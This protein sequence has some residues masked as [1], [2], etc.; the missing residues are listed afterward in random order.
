[1]KNL[2]C[3]KC[4]SSEF[5]RKDG[6]YVCLYCRS[7]VAPEQEKTLRVSMDSRG[8][9]VKFDASLELSN[10]YELA[11]RYLEIGDYEK[12]LKY[13]EMILLQDP[14]NWEATFYIEYI[15]AAKCKLHEIYREGASLNNC[16]NPVMRLIKNHISSKD[17][18]IRGVNEVVTRC[19]EL[20]NLFYRSS[21]NHFNSLMADA[22][23]AFLAAHNDNLLVAR[24][25]PYAL[26][27]SIESC[28]GNY[29]ELHPIMVNSWKEGIVKHV[30]SL[31]YLR[32][33]YS[34]KTIK[35]N[36]AIIKA[37]EAKVKRFEPAY[38]H[39]NL[40]GCYVATAVYG[41]YDCP[42]VRTL[43][44]FRDNTL[45]KSVWGRAFI[46][47]YYAIS[48]TLVKWFGGTAWFTR[49]FRKRLDRFVAKL[50]QEGI[51]NTPYQD[52]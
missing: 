26:G 39:P 14:T 2:I 33:R 20:S 46:H 51:E 23:K 19:F 4:G 41:S 10:L 12:A 29:P 43:R 6:K 15:E 18:Q 3:D 31:K 42:E 35:E 27:D 8:S 47:T 52:K 30:G 17:E 9:K 44:R 21:V 24:T 37:Y 34:N 32:I 1:M 16:I 48:P 49:F 45:S 11:R 25:I 13:Y 38:N 40:N 5:E 36:I 28:F 50:N 22:K 7:K